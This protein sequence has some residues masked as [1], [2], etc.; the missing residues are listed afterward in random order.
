MQE[1]IVQT[2]RQ[3]ETTAKQVFNNKLLEEK[4]SS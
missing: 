4:T 2:G 1:N 3:T